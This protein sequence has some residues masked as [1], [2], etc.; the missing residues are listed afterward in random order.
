LRNTKTIKTPQAEP[1]RYQRTKFITDFK[2]TCKTGKINEVITLVH[3]KG[4]ERIEKVYEKWQLITSHTARR[5]FITNGLSLG[6]GSEVIRSWTGHKNDKSFNVYYEIV[7][8]R[9]KTDIQLLSL[10]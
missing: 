2:N 7:K 9:K 3:Y 5:S 8:K 4:A 1:C 10:K 6:I